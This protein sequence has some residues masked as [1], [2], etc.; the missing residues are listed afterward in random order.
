VDHTRFILSKPS[1][2]QRMNRVAMAVP[3]V[4]LVGA[5]SR[6]GAAGD[7]GRSTAAGQGA[8]SVAAVDRVT[9]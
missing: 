1:E 7:C 3:R 6:S 8:G 5:S 4:R 9:M 2:N